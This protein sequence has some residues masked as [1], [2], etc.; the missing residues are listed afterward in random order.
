VAWAQITSVSVWAVRSVGI[1]GPYHIAGY[2]MGGLIAYQ[3]A[4]QLRSAGE[5]VRQVAVVD[6]ILES[7]GRI[8]EAADFNATDKSR[9]M[10]EFVREDLRVLDFIGE[11]P[12]EDADNRTYWDSAFAAYKTNSANTSRRVRRPLPTTSE[13]QSTQHTRG[14]GVPSRAWVG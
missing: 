6:T 14:H 7:D 2:C 10:R 1:D 5:L 8:R 9:L 12:R 13:R 11:M 4:R 3:I